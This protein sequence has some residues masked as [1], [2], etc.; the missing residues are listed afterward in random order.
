MRFLFDPLVLRDIVRLH[1]ALPVAARMQAVSDTLVE[2]Y[3]PH[4][5]PGQ[6]WIW[7]NAG[8]IMCAMSVLHVSPSEYLLFC[9]TAIGTEGHSGRHR[10]EV[11]DVVIDGQLST[12]QPAD[13]RAQ[14]YQ[15]G[16]LASLAPKTV[17]GSKLSPGCWLLEY[18][19]GNVA[20][21]FPFALADS[22]FST[23]DLVDVRTQ[24]SIA[25]KLMAKEAYLVVRHALGNTQA[26]PN[27]APLV[28]NSTKESNPTKVYQ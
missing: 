1:L 19:R 10:S 3:G 2:V 23:L 14:R 8:G 22:F 13:S 26:V 9:G 16:D 27:L 20:S 15:P 25:T 5:H 4:V 17:N 7:S 21:M 24:L 12:F 6:P 18:A 28:E 11:F